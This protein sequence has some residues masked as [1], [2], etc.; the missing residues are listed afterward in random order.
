MNREGS[1][2]PNDLDPAAQEP[3]ELTV[4]ARLA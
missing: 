3:V 4:L 2:G 1:T